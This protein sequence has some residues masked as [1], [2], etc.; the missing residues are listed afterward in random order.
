MEHKS[1]CEGQPLKTCPICRAAFAAGSTDCWLCGA[2]RPRGVACVT[3][4]GAPGEHRDAVREILD[5]EFNTRTFF[6]TIE[7][8]L[9]WTP[10]GMWRI[11]D[12]AIRRAPIAGSVNDSVPEDGWR[13]VRSA[14]ENGDV[15]VA[16]D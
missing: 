2:E 6:G 12:V 10:G 3:W 11:L 9:E 1:K 4:T 16:D 14:L 7:V 13:L 8:S 5:L 15:P